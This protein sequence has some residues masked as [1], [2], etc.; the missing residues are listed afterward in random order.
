MI[1][2]YKAFGDSYGKDTNHS[3]RTN[4]REN[5]Y[6]WTI[7]NLTILYYFESLEIKIQLFDFKNSFNASSKICRI[8]IS[9]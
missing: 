9:L 7:S 6:V 2:N 1:I 3:K 4:K 5:G 8:F